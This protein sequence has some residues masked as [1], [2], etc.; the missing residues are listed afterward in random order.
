MVILP[1]IVIYNKIVKTYWALFSGTMPE[2]SLHPSGQLILPSERLPARER[3]ESPRRAI[4][5]NRCLHVVE[6]CNGSLPHLLFLVFG[7][8]LRHELFETGRTVAVRYPRILQR[9]FLA[10]VEL[11]D[12]ADC[13]HFVSPFSSALVTCESIP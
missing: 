6:R 11:A 1:Y 9:L 3:K 12:T 2:A 5:S 10:H 7:A 13:F 8:E 4:P